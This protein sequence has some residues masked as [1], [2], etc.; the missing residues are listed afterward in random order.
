MASLGTLGERASRA[1]GGSAGDEGGGVS[2]GGAGGTSTES[3][4]WSFEDVERRQ[5]RAGSDAAPDAIVRARHQSRAPTPG[6]YGEAYNAALVAIRGS[7]SSP[8]PTTNP[9]RGSDRG[10]DPGF[11]DDPEYAA[12]VEHYRRGLRSG[13]VHGTDWETE[14]RREDPERDALVSAAVDSMVARDNTV[15]VAKHQITL[16]VERRL[17]R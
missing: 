13:N 8:T 7:Q 9:N 6:T 17:A 3:T 11:R 10:S 4:P 15:G 5:V 16:D 12:L 1:L 14:R 2:G